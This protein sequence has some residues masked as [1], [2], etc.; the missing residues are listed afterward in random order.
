MDFS[1]KEMTETSQ[2]RLWFISISISAFC[3]IGGFGN[4]IS[5]IIFNNKLFKKQATRT[6]LHASF[7][8]SLL[9]LAYSPIVYLSPAWIINDLNCKIYVGI[10]VLLTEFKAF[11]QAI[12]S[13]DRLISTLKPQ[14][15]F[16][17]NKL[18]YQILIMILI[19]LLLVFLI[20]PAYAFFTTITIRNVTICS[21]PRQVHTKWIVVYSEIQYLCFRM[22]FPFLIMLTSS[23]IVSWKIYKSK[24]NLTPNA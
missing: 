5:V 21:F 4:I 24:T 3:L 19:G 18:K 13:L 6:Y 23:C 16:F 20:L 14:K 2:A 7:L 10:L 15:F 8:I 22:L 9:I 1:L 12:G 17:K 11:I